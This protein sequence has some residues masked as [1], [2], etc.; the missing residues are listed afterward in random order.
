M[1]LVMVTGTSAGVVGDGDWLTMTPG[2]G[3]RHP[4][5]RCRKAKLGVCGAV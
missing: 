1:L 2:T 5:G 3:L 4:G